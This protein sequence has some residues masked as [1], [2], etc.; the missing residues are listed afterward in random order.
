[1]IS[2][3]NGKQKKER[4]KKVKRDKIKDKRFRNNNYKIYKLK[5]SICKSR[6]KL[7]ILYMGVSTLSIKLFK[8]CPIEYVLFPFCT[9]IK[10]WEL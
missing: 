2:I 5:K 1:M 6:N 9:K 4:Y 7:N 3:S 10:S 8:P